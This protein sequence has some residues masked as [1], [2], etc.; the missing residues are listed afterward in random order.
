MSSQASAVPVLGRLG[1]EVELLAPRGSD[2][3]VLA[4]ELASR[5]GGRVQAFLHPD[6]EPSKVEG[7]ELFH[8]LT[9]GWSVL[10]PN[11][12]LLA[13]VVDDI[14]L[15]DD[16]E[17]TAAPAPGWW[18]VVSD[19]RRLLTLASRQAD[20]GVPLPAAVQPVADLFGVGVEEGPGGMYRVCLPDG[21]PVLIAA[22]MPGQR[23]RAAE[24][25]TAPIST[26]HEATLAWMLDVATGLGFG[27]PAEGATHLH[28]DAAPLRDARALRRF[29]QLVRPLAEQLRSTAASNPRCR[30]LGPWPQ[31]LLDAVAAPGWDDLPWDA[32][33][34]RLGE[35]GL[36]KYCDVNLVNVLR[37]PPGK[38][39]LELRILPVHLR[40]G[41]IVAAAE[42]LAALVGAAAGDDPLPDS[43][44]L[45][46][47][48]KALGVTHALGRLA[49]GSSALTD[50]V[51]APAS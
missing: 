17:R 48:A 15:Q 4:R 43:G 40:A 37:P 26:D 14:T 22:P 36:T 7:T 27:A 34:T 41:P 46:D 51:T 8:N 25:V 5:C 21:A 9:L 20:P 18:R 33:V 1:V 50:Q 2:R 38:D 42:L 29:V 35:A 3:A 44:D 31:A 6:A 45:P 49:D 10:E 19:D 47:V 11:G 39:T 30:R 16:L 13:R 23:E 12:N 24:L 28:V 32:V